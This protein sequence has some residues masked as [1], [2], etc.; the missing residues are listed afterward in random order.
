VTQAGRSEVLD[1]HGISEEDLISF[2]Q[3][4]GE[5]LIFCRKFG[6]KLS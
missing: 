3:A 2:A 4:N 5:D 6:M 1:R